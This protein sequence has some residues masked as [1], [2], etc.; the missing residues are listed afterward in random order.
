MKNAESRSACS[1]VLVLYLRI[2]PKYLDDVAV[3]IDGDDETAVN[4][5]F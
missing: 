5:L 3:R 1:S 4:I 2:T